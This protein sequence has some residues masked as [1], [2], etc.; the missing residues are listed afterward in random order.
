MMSCK[1]FGIT[2]LYFKN[3]RR[4]VIVFFLIK[5]LSNLEDK[6]KTYFYKGGRRRG[7]IKFLN[8]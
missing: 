5:S 6:Y 1:Y 4:F 7:E 8:L 2:K 3:I